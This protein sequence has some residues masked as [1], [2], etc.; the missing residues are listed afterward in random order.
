[1]KVRKRSNSVTSSASTADSD[2]ND[3]KT[4]PTTANLPSTSDS[5]SELIECD[6]R[7][8]SGPPSRVSSRPPSRGGNVCGGIEFSQCIPQVETPVARRSIDINDMG[9]DWELNEFKEGKAP[10]AAIRGHLKSS[11]PD[12][13][14]SVIEATCEVMEQATLESTSA[15]ITH[16]SDTNPFVRRA[17]VKALSSVLATAR[18]SETVELARRSLK[19]A[20]PCIKYDAIEALLPFAKKGKDRALD[21]LDQYRLHDTD[22]SIRLKAERSLSEMAGSAKAVKPGALHGARVAIAHASEALSR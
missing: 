20:D 4:L 21:A 8:S 3:H 11:D 5:G 1:M 7:G 14:R 6:S 2:G 9:L 19:Q 15:L 16:L 18:D 22:P 13:R 10:F 17:S 12:I